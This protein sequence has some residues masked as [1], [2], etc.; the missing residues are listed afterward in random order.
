MTAP[1]EPLKLTPGR[2]YL[3]REGSWSTHLEE[4]RVVAR[5]KTGVYIEHE[6]GNRRWHM[7]AY[8]GVDKWVIEEDLGPWEP[9]APA[10]DDAAELRAAVVEWSKANKACS[11]W[12]AG[13]AGN[14]EDELPLARL[15]RAERHLH[16]LAATE[17]QP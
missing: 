16:A 4:V 13:T 1:Q 3:I 14:D 10:R 12:V 8:A 7:L 15:S 5:S 6:S 11:Q 2:R 17:V 9:D